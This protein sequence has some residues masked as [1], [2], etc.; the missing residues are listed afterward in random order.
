MTTKAQTG[1]FIPFAASLKMAGVMRQT[2]DAE[3]NERLGSEDQA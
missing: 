1:A 2:I 3:T